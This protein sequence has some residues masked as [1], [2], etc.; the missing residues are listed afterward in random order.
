MEFPLYVSPY[1][2]DVVANPIPTFAASIAGVLAQH[3]TGSVYTNGF[4]LVMTQYADLVAGT[5]PTLPI[6]L[7]TDYTAGTLTLS[8]SDPSFTLQS[9]TNVAGPYVDVPG[10]S[11]PFAPMPP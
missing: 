7:V 1:V 6:P 5:P 2:Y 4:Q 10:A 11:S 8:W 3:A 9:S